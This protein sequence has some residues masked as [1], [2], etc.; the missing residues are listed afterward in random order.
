MDEWLGAE[1]SN[2]GREGYSQQRTRRR[3]RTSRPTASRWETGVP[4]PVAEPKH[5]FWGAHTLRKASTKCGRTLRHG[6]V[7]ASNG[8]I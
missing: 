8:L 7:E 2:G 3:G 6:D 5:L 4:D 1:H